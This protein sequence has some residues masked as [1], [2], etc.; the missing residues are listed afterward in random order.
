M[1]DLGSIRVGEFI[2]V[3]AVVGV[4]RSIEQVLGKN[5]NYIVV[6][7]KKGWVPKNNPDYISRYNIPVKW[8][9]RTGWVYKIDSESLCRIPTGQYAES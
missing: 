3:G 4:G 5:D 8:H 9:S 6:S 7:Y 2:V 1:N